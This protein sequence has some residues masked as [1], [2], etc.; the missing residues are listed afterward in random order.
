MEKSEKTNILVVE[1]SALETKIIQESLREAKNISFDLDCVNK[2]STAVKK[3]KKNKFDIIL[4]D[5]TLPDSSGLETFSRLHKHTNNTPIIILSSIEDEELA[6][7]AVKS[8]AQDYLVKG[9][10]DG[11][12]LARAIRYAIE[13]KRVEEELLEAQEKLKK[14]VEKRTSELSETSTLLTEQINEHEQAEKRQQSI[15]KISKAVFSAHDLDELY[16]LIHSIISELMPAKNCYIALYDHN[17]DMIS[18]PYM[19]DERDEP[20]APKKFGKGLTEYV[21]L[22]G[23]PLLTTPEIYN[24]LLEKGE[25]EI[26]GTR[27]VDWLGVPLKVKGKTIGVLAVQSYTK[28]IRY[29]DKEKDILTYVSDQIA[30]AIERE[31][32]EQNLRTEKAYLEQLFE[33]AHE[34]IVMTDNEGKVLRANSEFS[35]LFGYTINEILGQQLDKLIAPDDLHE[36]AASSTNQVLNGKKI[37]FDSIRRRKDGTLIDVSV[38]ASPIIIDGE[39]V[40]IYGIYRDITERKKAEEELKNSY[41]RL[42]KATEGIID[43]MALTIET[44]DPYTA[45]HQRRVADLACA[46]ATELGLKKDQISAIRMAG[47][48]H[49]LGKIHVPSEI[50]SKPGQLTE[51]EFALIQTHPRIAYDILKTIEFPWPV[52]T[53]VLQHHERINGSGYPVGLYREDILLEARI[54]C[55]ADV[56]EA[57]SSHRPYRP[58]LGIEKALEEIKQN[59]GVLYDPNVVDKCL[60]LFEKKDFK[61]E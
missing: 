45:G 49:D 24:E 41:D 48:I 40:G 46:I 56:V 39:Q 55:V 4:L 1:D 51:I 36:E 23:K 10:V 28:G 44:K 3:A 6:L 5:L 47:L 15:Y 33:S 34:A 2:L 35:N 9:K 60:E 61:F 37:D 54:L 59:K 27:G 50:L 53:I 52:A 18:F 12:L 8:G 21:L 19:V 58:A 38:L 22:T 14:R 26:V 57:M 43:I 29:G 16:R 42:Q 30:M 25:I 31:R 32:A 20:F 11:G 13:R 7:N 17:T